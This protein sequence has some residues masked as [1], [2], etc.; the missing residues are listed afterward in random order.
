MRF[1][2]WKIARK[3]GLSPPRGHDLLT[4]SHP[5]ISAMKLFLYLFC[6][7]L[8]L[9]GG[10]FLFVHD[11]APAVATP[12]STW[13]AEAQTH[14]TALLADQIQAA[15]SHDWK[16]FEADLKKAEAHLALA[17]AEADTKNFRLALAGY[18]SQQE[19]RAQ[20]PQ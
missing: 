11:S 19:M 10:Y 8:L 1:R 13:Q 9:G 3:R 14:L 7:V 2:E 5:S 18:R 6:T 17:P 15:S 4:P 16:P 12:A 20:M